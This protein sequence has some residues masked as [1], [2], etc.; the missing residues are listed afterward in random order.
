MNE[1]G[2]L[3]ANG[4]VISGR[5]FLSRTDPGSRTRKTIFGE[6]ANVRLTPS[7]QHF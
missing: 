3:G 5:L 4:Q 7:H 2:R 1:A 6:G